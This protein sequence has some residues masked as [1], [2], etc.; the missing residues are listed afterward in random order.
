M[1]AGPW[2]AEFLLSYIQLTKSNNQAQVF[3]QTRKPAQFVKIQFHYAFQSS[4]DL[5]NWDTACIYYVHNDP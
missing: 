3:M 4:A 5:S 1:E 2:L